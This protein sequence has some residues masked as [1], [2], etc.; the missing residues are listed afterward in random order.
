[1]PLCAV[2]Y[3]DHPERYIVFFSTVACLESPTELWKRHPGPWRQRSDGQ[4]EVLRSA[5]SGFLE[6]IMWPCF[7]LFGFCCVAANCELRTALSPL[8]FALLHLPIC[9]CAKPS[10]YRFSLLSI[11][12]FSSDVNIGEQMVGPRPA[13]ARVWSGLYQLPVTSGMMEPTVI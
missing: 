13:A 6:T 8:R 3:T 12:K 4:W 1:M 5:R 2:P 7:F 9:Q 11:M 10:A